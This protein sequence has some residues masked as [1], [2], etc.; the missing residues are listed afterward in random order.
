[1]NRLKTEKVQV[2]ATTHRHW[3]KELTPILLAGETKTVDALL[4]T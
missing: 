2:A 3:K 4:Q 1:M